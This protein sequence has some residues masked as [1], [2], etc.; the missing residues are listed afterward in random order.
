MAEQRDSRKLTRADVLVVTVVCL[1]LILLVSVLFARPREVSIRRHC[2]ANLAQIGK[3]MFLYA[4]DNEG[5]LPRAGGRNTI[6]GGMPSTGWMAPNRW[7][8]FGLGA[9]GLGGTAS[10]NA[11]FYL[12]VKYLQLS[13]RLFVCK[14]DEGTTEFKLSSLPVTIPNFTLSDAWDF[15]PP[16]ESFKHCSY[17]YHIPYGLHALNTSLDPNLAVAADRNPWIVSPAS[18]PGVWA[19]FRPDI[20]YVGGAVGI[21]RTARAG[22]SIS[23]RQ[24]GQNVLFL[25]GRVTF[26]K[27]AYCALD[28]DN[29]YTVSRDPSTGDPYGVGLPVTGSAFVPMNRKDSLLAHD[30]DAFGGRR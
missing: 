17:A 26:E 12:L 18:A 25:D 28:K 23:H 29:I 16:S 15:G 24:D 9:D 7:T 21:P 22:N 3:A 30:P 8:A 10:I 11:S 13:P 2:A 14:G 5:E 20:P 1:L 6:W 19:D 4:G 27:R